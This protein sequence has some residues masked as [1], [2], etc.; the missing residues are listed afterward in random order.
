MVV[1]D[2]VDSECRGAPSI[3]SLPPAS[4]EFSDP[5]SG[6]MMPKQKK[7]DGVQIH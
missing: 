1:V 6:V 3:S 2:V 5:F 4:A 7:R